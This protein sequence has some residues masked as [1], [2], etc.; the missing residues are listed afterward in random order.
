MLGVVKIGSALFNSEEGTYLESLHNFIK[1]FNGNLVFVTGAGTNAK[2]LLDTYRKFKFPEGF[3]DHIGIELTHINSRVFSRLIKGTYCK[4]FSEI[5][6]NILRKPVTGGQVPGQSTDAVAAEVA[7]FLGADLLILVKDV[8]GIYASDPKTNPGARIM[9]KMTF[10]ELKDLIATKTQAGQ[11][12]VIDPQ[13]YH[14]IRRSKI[15]TFVVGPT[16]KFEEGTEIKEK[17]NQDKQTPKSETET[18][19][20]SETQTKT[21]F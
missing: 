18:Q 21:W 13:A 15:R 10:D 17:L 6:K 7:D 16:F 19:Q 11:Y 8:G 5:E 2:T 4:D 1:S 20:T 14:I 3:L 9:H 12:G